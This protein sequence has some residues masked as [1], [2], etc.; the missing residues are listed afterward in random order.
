MLVSG[1]LLVGLVA[2]EDGLFEAAAA[3]LER[4]PGPPIALFAA[5]CVAVAL[6]TALLNLDTSA[7]FLLSLIHI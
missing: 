7:V 1:L 3:R 2:G 6:T 5:C 4:L